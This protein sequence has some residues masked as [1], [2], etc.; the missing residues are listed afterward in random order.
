MIRANNSDDDD[1]GDYEVIKETCVNQFDT[2]KNDCYG[3][4]QKDQAH[5]TKGISYPEDIMP[6]MREMCYKSR[7]FLLFCSIILITTFAAAVVA[8]IVVFVLTANLRSDIA[9]T[10]VN[11]LGCTCTFMNS[12]RTNVDDLYSQFQML[13]NV[14]NRLSMR[15]SKLEDHF[16]NLTNTQGRVYQIKREVEMKI[17]ELKSILSAR[18]LEYTYNMTSLLNSLMNSVSSNISNARDVVQQSVG[19]LTSKIVHDVQSLV[20]FESCA[21]VDMLSLPFSSGQYMIKTSTGTVLTYCTILSCNGTGWRR[22]AYLNTSDCSADQCPGNLEK[23]GTLGQSNNSLSCRRN[24]FEPGCSSVVYPNNGNSYSHVCGMINA[25]QVGSP[26]GFRDSVSDSIEGTYVDG[27]S[28]THG[29]SP[30]NHIWTFA[31]Q[32]TGSCMYCNGSRPNFIGSHYSCESNLRC[33]SYEVCPIDV[34]WNG[35][36]CVGEAW[37]YRSLDHPT[38]DDIEMRVCRSQNQIDEDFQINLVELYVR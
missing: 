11:N 35:D 32:V 4:V 23:I 12:Q 31:A 22:V 18:I 9:S 6:Q 7:I 29:M 5:K 25:Y 17:S 38:T 19:E 8:L 1:D 20:K 34:L 36:Q 37:F 30:R 13:L 14:T 2:N 16:N 33:Y 15:T 27:V 21:A 26:D 24:V 28:L 3:I 10:T